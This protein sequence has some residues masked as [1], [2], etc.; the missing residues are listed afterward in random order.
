MNRLIIIG[1]GFDLA[2]DLKTRYSDF[3]DFLWKK[4][5]DCFYKSLDESNYESELIQVK[6]RNNDYGSYKLN[7]KIVRSEIDD[8][9]S[10]NENIFK[11]YW[12]TVTIKNKFLKLISEERIQNWVDIEN[13]YY[14]ILINILKIGGKAF[15]FKNLQFDN[16]Y[17]IKKLNE[18]FQKVINLF[19]EYLDNINLNVNEIDQIKKHFNSQ[20]DFDDFSEEIL[21]KIRN[22]IEKDFDKKINFQNDRFDKSFLE[23]IKQKHLKKISS[24]EFIN[25]IPDRIMV[26]NF[27]YTK[28][29]ELYIKDLI[30]AEIVYIHGELNNEENPIIFGFGDEMDDDYNEI[31]KINN[32]EFLNYIKSINYLR[33]DNYKKLLRFIE[34]DIFQVFIMGHSCGNSDRTMLNTIFEHD[35]CGSIKYFYYKPS[36]DSD[37]YIEKIQNISRSFSSKIKMRDRIV[38]KK[39]S[40][41]LT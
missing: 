14:S 10:F 13:E 9:S 33:T 34:A 15:S 29:P 20:F 21:S 4:E 27:N 40:T 30:N 23:T 18:E 31:E 7:S 32:N 35:N 28:T 26:L 12:L 39:F 41:S 36:K 38:N 17:S 11:H 24:K 16:Q 2:H 19:I 37:D 22:G 3:I 5:A 8:F 1:N 25:S 6:L